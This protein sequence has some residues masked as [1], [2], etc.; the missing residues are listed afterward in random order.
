MCVVFLYY[1][2][3]IRVSG[4]KIMTEERR[5]VLKLDNYPISCLFNSLLTR[6]IF[7]EFRVIWRVVDVMTE[8]KWFY[9]LPWFL[10]LLSLCYHQLLAYFILAKSISFFFS[11]SLRPK[12]SSSH[13]NTNTVHASW[14]GI[15]QSKDDGLQWEIRALFSP[16]RDDQ[17]FDFFALTQHIDKSISVLASIQENIDCSA[18]WMGDNFS[19]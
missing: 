7:E 14:F 15:R 17:S 2:L 6:Q 5:R 16:R 19:C 8:S 3:R 10:H 9:C 4:S 11:F 1:A 18:T 12:F 13:I